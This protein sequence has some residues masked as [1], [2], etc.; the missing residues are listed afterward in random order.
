MCIARLNDDRFTTT[1]LSCAENVVAVTPGATTEW[2][3]N[4]YTLL[5]ELC[6]N[7]MY[8]VTYLVNEQQ[9]WPGGPAIV[10]EHLTHGTV[11]TQC[12]Y[13]PCHYISHQA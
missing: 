7:D 4:V 10:R 5:A 12:Q 2:R 8:L 6:H 13:K 11:D 1:T 3:D 9:A